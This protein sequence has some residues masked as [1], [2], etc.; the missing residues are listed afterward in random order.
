MSTT[1]TPQVEREPDYRPFLDSILSDIQALPVPVR[2]RFA[3]E[4]ADRYVAPPALDWASLVLA[5]AIA[6]GVLL[7][8]GHVGDWLARAHVHHHFGT[9]AGWFALGLAAVAVLDGVGAFVGS[10]YAAIAIR[11]HRR[12]YATTPTA[13]TPARIEGGLA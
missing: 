10:V 4:V 1:N 6:A 11:R 7:G 9:H 13:S 8:R 5:A 2:Q 12:Q 3:A